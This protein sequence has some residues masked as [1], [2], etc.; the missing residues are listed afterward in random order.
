MKHIHIL[1]GGSSAEH[2]ISLRTGREVLLHIDHSRYIT[3]AVVIS[4][5]GQWFLARST[6]QT[7][8]LEELTNPQKSSSFIGPF[9]LAQSTEIW[10]G[11]ECAFLALHGSFGEDGIIQGYLEAVQI[12]YTGSGVFASAIA[13]NKIA[14][15][16]IFNQ[17]GIS[18]PPFSLW[19]VNHPETS[20]DTIE[21]RHG[22]PCFVKC[23]QSGSSRLMGRANSKSELSALLNE[24]KS[25]ANEILVESAVLGVE[26]SCPVLEKPDGEVIALPV[27]EI[28]PKAT[29]FDFTA[30]YTTGG[31]EE[32]VPAPYPDH[33]T[34][35]V[36]E[37]ALTAH[38]AIGC[39]GLTRTDVMW[40][41]DT[42]YALELNSLP[43][44]TSHSLAPKSFMSVGG[45]YSG[46]IDILI[47]TAALKKR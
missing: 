33:I 10:A 36:Q 23:P 22:F 6:N 38:K 16:F 47:A 34:K 17:V 2:E 21:K 40:A 8:S 42:L 15:K 11:C 37:I 26:F 29:F 13:M 30:K 20:V 9:S 18:T 27:I 19:G 3:R 28:R 14:T 35:K 1:M 41:H 7:P 24:F 39:S 4:K 43:G 25:E 32:I 31:S 5:D 46:L 44:L 12:P 45:T